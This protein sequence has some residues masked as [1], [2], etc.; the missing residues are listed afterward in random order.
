MSRID[1]GVLCEAD[2]QFAALAI[3]LCDAEAF[4]L[5]AKL[6]GFEQINGG[7]G[8]MCR[9]DLASRSGLR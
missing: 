5:E 1:G 9:S 2:L 7:V 3:D 8:Q 4:A 6:R